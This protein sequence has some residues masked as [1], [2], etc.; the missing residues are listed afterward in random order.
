MKKEIN[1]ILLQMQNN[2]IDVD[3]AANQLLNLF[4]VSN[5]L[6]CSFEPD[7]RTSSATRCKCGR[8]KWEH[9]KAT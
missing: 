6:C 5:L 7:N 8:E 9:P 2:N 1:N 3:E 4:S